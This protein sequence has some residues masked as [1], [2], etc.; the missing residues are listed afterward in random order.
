MTIDENIGYVQGIFYGAYIASHVSTVG[1]DA[2]MTPAT[3]ATSM[4][5]SIVA[6]IQLAAKRANQRASA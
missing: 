5:A 6:A 4:R 2:S 3:A 1:I